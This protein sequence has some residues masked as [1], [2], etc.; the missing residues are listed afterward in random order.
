MATTYYFFHDPSQFDCE[1]CVG[2]E[3]QAEQVP[4]AGRS[5]Q[6]SG[7][8]GGKRDTLHRRRADGK[9]LLRD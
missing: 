9:R 1:R 8:P 6:G 3:G 5:D 4:V 7:A 2:R